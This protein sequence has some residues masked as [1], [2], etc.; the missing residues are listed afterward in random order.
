MPGPRHKDLTGQKF[1]MLTA[2][3]FTKVSPG[4]QAYWLFRC[5]CGNEKEVRA[6]HAKTGQIKSCGC[7]TSEL[8]SQNGSKHGHYKGDVATPE[9]SAWTQAKQRC[10]SPTHQSFFRYGARGIAMCDR[11]R[12]GDGGLSGF[13]CFIADM[14]LRPEGGTL[15][16]I[17]NDKGYSPDNCRWVSMKVQGRNRSDNLVIEFQGEKI[18]ATEAAEK[19]GLRAGLVIQRLRRG[20]SVKRALKPP[21]KYNRRLP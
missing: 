13:E 18:C 10:H 7:S 5:D 14:G 3:R 12:D 16:R 11:W 6:N 20:W 21:N 17:D 1:N 8:M 2:V 9:Y 15:D 19:V 4:G